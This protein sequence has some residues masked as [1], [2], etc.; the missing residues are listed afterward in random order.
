MGTGAEESENVVEAG[1]GR[2]RC[3]EARRIRGDRDGES[4]FLC[5][6]SISGISTRRRPRPTV[7]FWKGYQQ[8]GGLMMGDVAGTSGGFKYAF[9]VRLVAPWLPEKRGE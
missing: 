7:M 3:A 6:A 9:L 8:L 4:V 5:G 1:G 2:R